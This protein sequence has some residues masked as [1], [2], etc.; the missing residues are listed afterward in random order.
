M[1]AIVVR[2]YKTLLNAS[3]QILGWGDAPKAEGWQGDLAAVDE[4]LNAEK[5]IF[6]AVYSSDLERAR[7]TAMYYAKSR[8][9]HVVH[10]S[11]LLNEVN[12]GTLYKKKKKWVAKHIPQHKKDPDFV[13]PKG[14]SFRDMQHRSVNFILSLAESRGDQT[15]LIVVHAGVIRGLVSHFLKLDYANHLTQKISHRY[16]G[17]FLFKGSSCVR[18]NELGNLSGFVEEGG[19]TV[20]YDNAAMP[21]RSASGLNDSASP[22]AAPG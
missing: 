18:Y 6:D 10:D 8:R 22:P 11:P 20:P 16:I 19:I 14:E 17:D 13:Y 9:I 15:L 12:Y 3:D 1:R 5:I 21:A 4:N 2:H 7:R